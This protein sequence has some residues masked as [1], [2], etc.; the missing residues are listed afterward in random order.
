[1]KN[2]KSNKGVALTISLLV[3]TVIIILGGSFV[4]RSISEKKASDRELMS[5]KAFYIADGG[6][7]D[8]LN[9]LNTL[10]NTN[11]LATINGTNPQT[12]GND[13]EQYVG[14]NN[15]L[16]FLIKYAKVGSAAQF[17]LN[18][19]QAKYTGTST[20]LGN[21]SYRYDII[22]TA[23]GNPVTTSSDQWDFPYYYRI[24]TTGT[25]TGVRKV[26]VSGDFTVRVQR[27]NFAKYALFTDHHTL[28]SGT[29][30]WFTS[31][32]NFAGPLHSND[33]LNFAFNPSGTF[34]GAVTSQNAK[35][36]F[37]NNNNPVQVNADSNPPNDVPTFNA[38]FT[39]GVSQIVLA[40][41]V[42]KQDL[43]DQ[44]RA[45]DNTPGNGI[46]VAN[47][48][49]SV[50]GGVYVSG[51][52]TV[53]LGVDASDNATYTITQG[54]TT[55]TITADISNNQTKVQTGATTQTYAGLPD[56]VDNI[57]SILYV[58][59][60]ITSLSGTVQKDTELTVSSEN[61]IVF[62]NNVKYADYNASVGTPGTAGY[63][64]PNA[65]GK[66][67]L[68]GIV[69][70]GGNVRVGSSAPND[71]EM[72]GIMMA[73][74]GVF[75]V[76]NYSSGGSRG[77]AT[78]L[79]GVITQFYGAFGTV[80]GATG[81]IL[82]GYGRNFNYDDRTAAG[83]APPYFPSMQTFVAFTNDITDKVAWQE[84]GF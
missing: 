55:K 2:L 49:T 15:S 47:N 45:S 13:A 39:R 57:G 29:P 36:K 25:A 77:T 59:G 42:Q 60:A 61:D 5:T 40:S 52:A 14:N 28:P 83:K 70:W 79:G 84:G 1:M 48:G 81:Q 41:S 12:V 58:N 16:G 53:S 10:I 37:Y 43:I 8:G 68:L 63:T 76:D 21:G 19:S 64:P 50:T 34:Q 71:I 9:R 56:G 78:L 4:V 38:G 32:T 66:K 75:T 54:S 72:H 65:T 30:V 33:Q 23:K 44:A 6:S 82:T 17:V 3:V 80:N 22:V 62:T 26:A 67:N 51:D 31:F 7:Q 69:S 73:R 18:G 35:A 74:N 24:E 27:D 46:F 11:M 20:S